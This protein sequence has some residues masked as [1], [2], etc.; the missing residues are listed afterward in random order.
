[1]P[2]ISPHTRTATIRLIAA[3]FAAQRTQKAE[4]ADGQQAKGGRFG[5]HRWSKL[6]AVERSV[7]KRKRRVIDAVG[8]RKPSRS[9][10]KFGR[11]GGAVEVEDARIT[12]HDGCAWPELDGVANHRSGPAS[13]AGGGGRVC[14]IKTKSEPA[15][16]KG[17][18]GLA[19][20]P[21]IQRQGIIINTA[22]RW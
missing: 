6:L 11:G 16:P 15:K 13:R 5:H 9:R 20:R 7:M 10:L 8:N 17:L 12:R 4:R 14:N 21:Y 3:E 2:T 22:P 1:M 19:S 18:D